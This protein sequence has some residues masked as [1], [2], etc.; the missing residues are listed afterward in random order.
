MLRSLPI[1]VLV[2]V[3]LFVILWSAFT[4]PSQAQPSLS[5]EITATATTQAVEE[6]EP[7][8]TST[9]G[10]GTAPA[11]AELT[12]ELVTDYPLDAFPS[13][14]GFALSFNQP[15]DLTGDFLPVQID[16]YPDSSLSWNR[17]HTQLRV[18]PI[19]PLLP[20]ATYVVT[21]NPE[22]RSVGGARLSQPATWTIQVISAPQL[23]ERAPFAT[24][25]TN[26]RPTI[27]LTFDRPM[28]ANTITLTVKPELDLTFTWLQNNL[29]VQANEA[30]TI[31]QIYEFTLDGAA[32]DTAGTPIGRAITWSYRLPQPLDLIEWPAAAQ[33]DSTITL[34]FNYPVNAAG[35]SLNLQPA[36][37]HHLLPQTEAN[38]IQFALDE[39]LR[40]DTRYTAQL[41]G[42]LLDSGGDELPLPGVMAHETVSFITAFQPGNG[43][44]VHPAN[45]IALT[46]R[47]PMNEAETAAAFHIS[48]ET[49]GRI[50]WHDNTLEFYPEG[51][52]L[53]AETNYT[54]T[55]ESSARTAEGFYILANSA[56]WTFST[57]PRYL[58]VSFGD[59]PHVQVLNPTGRRA[60]QY[61]FAPDQPLGDVHF[62]LYQ[63]GLEQWLADGALDGGGWLAEWDTEPGPRGET[64]VHIAETT[65]PAD[66]P[67]GIYRL[68]LS[69]EGIV[70]DRL[71][72]FLSRHVL[73]LKEDQEQVLA[74]LSTLDGTIAADA[75]IRFYDGGGNLLHSGRTDANGLY[76][77]PTVG[78]DLTNLKV[79]ALSGEEIAVASLNDD[80]RSEY[81]TSY[82]QDSYRFHIF[83]DRPIYHPGET[84]YFRAIIRQEQDANLG[85]PPAGTPI[86]VWLQDN[87]W[88]T[89]QTLELNSSDFG[90]VH[91][92]FAL[93]AD[94]ATG[95]YRLLVS[96]NG[97]QNGISLPVWPLSDSDAYLV[98]VTTDAPIYGE[99]Q[100]VAVTVTVRDSAGQPVPNA[101]VSLDV[102]Y[103]GN[104]APCGSLHSDIG[105]YPNGSSRSGRTDDAGMYT[106][107]LT[108]EL[109][110]AGHN[111]GPAGSDLWHSPQAIEAVARIGGQEIKN[112]TVY[113]VAN[114]AEAIRLEIGSAIKA[115]GQP[116]PVQ[117]TV[118]NLSEQ[119]VAGRRLSLTLFAYDANSGRY[120]LAVQSGS[121]TTGGDGQAMLPFI[122]TNPGYYEL[123]LTGWDAAGREYQ[124]TTMVYAYDPAYSGPYGSADA[125]AVTADR[126]SYAPGET[127]R[128][129]IHSN[130]SGPA[131]LTFSRGA[132]YRSQVVQ[133]T[134]PL[135]LVEAPVTAADAPNIFVAVHAWQPQTQAFDSNDYFSYLS[136]QDGLLRRA[137]TLVRVID[138]A[139]LLNLTITPDT[140]EAIP[141]APLSVTVRVTNG[142]GEPV[143]AEL[144]L[145]LI[146][147]S[148]TPN[149]H[150]HSSAIA[151]AF[152]ATR[153]NGI[154]TY[155]SLQPTRYLTWDGGF[156][157]CGCGGDYGY[158]LEFSSPAAGDTIWLPTLVTDANGEAT[159]TVTLPAGGWRVVAK[160][161]T[162][163]TQV[164]ET[165]IT[166]AQP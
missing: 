57:S 103:A 123:R 153:P 162:A 38:T 100:E 160:A 86:T 14:A 42:Q 18:L 149:N 45:N 4:S 92:Q 132:I 121:L 151:N 13:Q 71:I 82:S 21:V 158:W 154:N 163:D 12:V 3:L 76:I 112:I 56:A 7:T 39:P 164:G 128:L 74:W 165:T 44:Q 89:V 118:T 60:V 85:L 26:R 63:L 110:Y 152:Y 117:A 105:W 107:T 31:N 30:L 9:G 73:V 113:E 119:P 2:V 15:V 58:R 33:S 29:L 136:Q 156:G 52:L 126:A 78:Y 65:L 59:G 48:P 34:H 108:A 157:G 97:Y 137:T 87:Q 146:D 98:N 49:A 120:D 88:Q 150:N 104:D 77:L 155:H 62:D 37:G 47:R 54:V 143:S 114:A 138:P 66:L 72:L 1:P 27:R 5:A 6:V 134:A 81:N 35:V 32:S 80:W 125:F 70:E 16:P 51:G 135:T 144:S 93:P 24:E 166:L 140:A 43:R 61:S 67:A 68:D 102:Y 141:G 94:A 96:A 53:A 159:V 25:L 106:V 133:L 75:E 101:T 147:A 11:P 28:D 145:A 139:K 17:S 127:A 22:L 40:G 115:P 161:V 130:F 129:A 20:G 84:V 142:R 50:E 79:V 111:A 69:F 64:Y 36:V 83:A 19:T 109:G 23:V 55:L 99:G 124:T 8:P 116:F 122:I 91:G 148:A 131:L 95:S 46:F 10:S 90:T 41:E